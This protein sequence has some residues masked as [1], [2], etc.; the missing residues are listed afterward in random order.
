MGEQYAMGKGG[1]CH[2]EGTQEKVCTHMRGRVTLLGRVRGGGVDCCKKLPA[3]E[4]AHAHGLSEGR[5]ALVQGM[6]WAVRSH[7]LH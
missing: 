1:E 5:V 7:L 3:L 4:L 6:I 2:A